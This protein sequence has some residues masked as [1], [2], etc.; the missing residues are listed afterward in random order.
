[1]LPYTLKFAKVQSKVGGDRTSA[2]K[3]HSEYIFV[4]GF[5][6][7]RW[8]HSNLYKAFETFGPILSAKVSMDKNHQSKG[9]GYIQ[10]EK[11]ED[12]MAAIEKVI[13]QFILTLY[14]R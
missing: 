6:K 3:E 4:K 2:A 9:Y 10:Y 7:Q 12:A 13:N 8:T 14:H 11:N 1:M 5:Q